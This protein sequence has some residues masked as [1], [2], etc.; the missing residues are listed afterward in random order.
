MDKGP[1]CNMPGLGSCLG[2]IWESSSETKMLN[3]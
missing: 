2:H 3:A 1:K